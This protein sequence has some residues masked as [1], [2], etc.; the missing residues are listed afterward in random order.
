M[1]WQAENCSNNKALLESALAFLVQ[2][3]SPGVSCYCLH[4]AVVMAILRNALET[5]AHSH[6]KVG[7]LLAEAVLTEAI[8]RACKQD[9]KTLVQ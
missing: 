9:P 8:A 5:R 7:E 1:Q 4:A 2:K 3:G 6:D